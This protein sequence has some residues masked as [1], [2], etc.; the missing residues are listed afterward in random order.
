MQLVK[1]S[2]G[3]FL[4]YIKPKMCVSNQCADGSQMLIHEPRFVSYFD[5]TIFNIRFFKVMWDRDIQPIDRREV[6]EIFPS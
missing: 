6:A 2:R 5:S 1:H 4:T 3:L